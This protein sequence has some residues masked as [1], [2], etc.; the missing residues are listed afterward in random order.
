MLAEKSS[1]LQG[2]S[3]SPP[4]KGAW[5]TQPVWGIYTR[6]KGTLWQQRQ[7]SMQEFTLTGLRC[8]TGVHL[9]TATAQGEENLLDAVESKPEQ[10]QIK[11]H[12]LP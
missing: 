3:S 10:S 11:C 7:S 1:Q 12:P 8:L 2:V 5:A 9:Q 6:A 4:S